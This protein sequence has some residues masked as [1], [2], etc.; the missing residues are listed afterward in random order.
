LFDIFQC[1]LI[2]T[3]RF[4]LVECIRFR[5]SI[6]LCDCGLTATQRAIERIPPFDLVTILSLWRN[7]GWKPLSTCVTYYKIRITHY[8][9]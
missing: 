1:F 9:R 7:R 8:K 5:L 2:F 3:H 6:R 4:H